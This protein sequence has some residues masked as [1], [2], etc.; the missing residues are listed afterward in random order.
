MGLSV[1]PCRTPRGQSKKSETVFPPDTWLNLGLYGFE[2][3]SWFSGQASLFQ[4]FPQA[5]TFDRIEGFL[6]DHESHRQFSSPPC[7]CVL[8]RN[9]MQCK[10]VINSWV[11]CTK[12]RLFYA[13]GISF[14]CLISKPLRQYCCKN[15][16][17]GAQ[18]GDTSVVVWVLSIS[19]F[20]QGNYYW[21][22]PAGWEVLS[23]IQNIKQISQ[24]GYMNEL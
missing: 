11:V 8:D 7:M 12:T 21:F 16:T 1:A 14:L 18:Q 4:N 10:Y 22:T 9:W 5:C 6:V 19:W 17:Y 3:I 15:L 23:F 24:K 13:K 20:V 2:H